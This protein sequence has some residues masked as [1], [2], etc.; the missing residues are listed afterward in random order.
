MIPDRP[1]IR[2]VPVWNPI[3]TTWFSPAADVQLVKAR[4]GLSEKSRHVC[5]IGAI[6]KHK[7][8]ECFLNMAVK[9]RDHVPDC[10]FHIIGSALTGDTEY[11]EQLRRMAVSLNL[12]AVVKFWGFVDDAV[13]RDLLQASDLFV[14]PTR[15]EGFCLA[16]AEAQACGV[17]VLTSALPPLDE[18]VENGQGGFLLD[19]EDAESFAHHAARLLLDQSLRSNM[20]IQAR[21]SVLAKFA[22]RSYALRIAAL[23]DELLE[24]LT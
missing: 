23:Y 12:A 24:D 19:P 17:P 21:T 13:A 2:V 20:S 22:V 7:G 18:L 11:A 1:G 14:L 3:D 16:V 6:A 4:L 9:L 15:E 10:Q 8:H 5:I